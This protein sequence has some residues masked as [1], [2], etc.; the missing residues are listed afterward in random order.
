MVQLTASCVYPAGARSQSQ[1]TER[2]TG[3]G[4]P[5]SRG[6]NLDRWSLRSA[7]SCSLQGE[8]WLF[9]CRCQAPLLKA[10]PLHFTPALVSRA[11]EGLWQL[12]GSKRVTAVCSC[13]ISQLVCV[14]GLCL[15]HT[16]C[17]M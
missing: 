13:V 3:A 16:K 12:P 1:G 10:R 6:H 7:R 17:A 15:A 2:V 14:L 8:V 9:I 4:R 5:Q 11:E